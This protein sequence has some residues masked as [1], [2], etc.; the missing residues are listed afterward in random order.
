M[1]HQNYRV[2]SLLSF[3]LT[4]LL[5]AIVSAVPANSDSNEKINVFVSILP[6]AYFV[7]RVGGEFVSIDVMV[8]PGQSPE[9]YSPTPRQMS[10]LDGARAYF[11]IG[12]PFENQLLRKIRE[13]YKKLDIV[14]TQE[15]IELRPMEALEKGSGHEHGALDPHVWLDP[16]AVKTIS[17]NICDELVKLD[18]AHQ[19]DY[20]KNLAEFQA[21]LDSLNSLIAI[22]LEPFKGR[23]IFVFHPVYGYFADRYGLQQTAVEIEGKEPSARQLASFIEMAKADSV[24]VIFVQPQ[25]ST[26]TAETIASAVGGAVVKV[27]PLA[28]DYLNNLEFITSRLVE[29]LGRK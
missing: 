19:P 14:S 18:P 13:V 27:D 7:E 12:L 17:K 8:S 22:K 6:Q 3:A 29:G 26:K 20:E 9:T 25:F 1:T 21:D 11:A 28:R 10:D 2:M 23:H 24:K 4:L 16:V 15:G 5:M